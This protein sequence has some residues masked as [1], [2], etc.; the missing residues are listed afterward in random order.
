MNLYPYHCYVFLFDYLGTYMG[1]L[2]LGNILYFERLVVNYALGY[3][4]GLFCCDSV[5]VL[6]PWLPGDWIVN[7]F[8][9]FMLYLGNQLDCLLLFWILVTLVSWII[10]CYS[11]HLLYLLVGLS[12]NVMDTCYVYQLG[13]L[14]LFWMLM[15]YLVIWF[16]LGLSPGLG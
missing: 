8:M 13:Y 1:H 16:L 9:K 3:T 6:C 14:S 15:I 4:L 5:D 2:L 7:L 10:Y 12:I 11:G